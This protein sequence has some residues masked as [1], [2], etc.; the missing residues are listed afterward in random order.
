MKI[1]II[2]Y[3]Y[4]G[5]ALAERLLEKGHE[6]WGL[7]RHWVVV[8]AGSSRPTEGAE[9]APLRGIRKIEADLLKPD[10][11]KNLPVFHA[12]VFCQ[13]PGKEDNYEQVYYQGT[14]NIL[15]ALWKQEI[16]KLIMVSSTS[17]YAQKDGAWVDEFSDPGHGGADAESLLKTEDLVLSE[18]HGIVFRLGGIYGPGRNRLKNFKV[19][20]AV[21]EPPL[22][23]VSNAYVNRIHVE[24]AAA[25]IML[26]L[27]KG[28]DREIYLGVDDLPVSQ[29]EF[30]EW[31]CLKLSLPLN[32]AIE[33]K[34][35]ARVSNKRCINKKIKE[36][37]L[38]LKYPTFKEGYVELI[39]AIKK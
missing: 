5:S 26:L 32:P 34:E 18:S 31:L 22:L 27:E 37:G 35:P 28:K 24:D 25:G 3:G 9:T 19:E 33:N 6:V 17:V 20:E 14:R 7:R 15:L 2:G 23:G 21:R 4:L 12:V 38:K 16:K 13:A 36:L 29:K 39:E 8:G 30:Y 10:S 1:L 11:L